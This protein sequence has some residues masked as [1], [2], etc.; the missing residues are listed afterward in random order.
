MNY[1]TENFIKDGILFCES[2]LNRGRRKF[3]RQ[4]YFFEITIEGSYSSM[5]M[6]I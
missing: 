4:S 1:N 5:D 3:D 2:K 6:F